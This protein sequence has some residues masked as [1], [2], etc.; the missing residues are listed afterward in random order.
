M[1]TKKII[2]L[3]ATCFIIKYSLQNKNKNIK[4]C[5]ILMQYS[6]CR[7]KFYNFNVHKYT[8]NVEHATYLYCW[9]FY[10]DVAA[11]PS[12][13][14]FLQKKKQKKSVLLNKIYIN[15]RFIFLAPRTTVCCTDLCRSPTM[16]VN[17]M[18]L[19]RVSVSDILCF[20]FIVA[21]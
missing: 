3:Y 1:Q 19:K 14:A 18:E 20:I 7:E 6:F 17:T 4:S 2:H 12:A 8:L 5:P 15:L 10:S 21:R 9:H 11:A 16:R 13:T